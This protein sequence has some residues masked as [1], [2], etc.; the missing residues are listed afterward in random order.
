[1]GMGVFHFSSA[2]DNRHYRE[3]CIVAVCFFSLHLNKLPWHLQPWGIK[4][5]ALYR[6][7]VLCSNTKPFYS[8]LSYFTIFMSFFSELASSSQGSPL[9]LAINLPSIILEP[10]SVFYI[11]EIWLHLYVH[12]SLS[13]VNLHFRYDFS[14]FSELKCWFNLSHCFI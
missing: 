7:I 2:W 4:Q 11:V 13:S 8:L 14:K 5:S 6:W 10:S 12:I 9:C 1:M 3:P